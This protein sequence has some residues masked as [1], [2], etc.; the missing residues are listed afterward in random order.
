MGQSGT[1]ASGCKLYVA[2]GISGAV[3]HLYGMKHIDTIIAINNDPGAPIFG[4]AKYGSNVDSLEL[5][6]ALEAHLGIGG[7]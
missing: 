6:T 3:Q 7:D 2:V 1:V 4:V 5:A